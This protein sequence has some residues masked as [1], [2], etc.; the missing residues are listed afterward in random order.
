MQR[1]EVTPDPHII[2]GQPQEGSQTPASL[3]RPIPQPAQAE[4]SA[5]HL[6]RSKQTSVPTIQW[7]CSGLSRDRWIRLWKDMARPSKLTTLTQNNSL[8]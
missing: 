6:L 5:P 3:L 1:K 7:A 2:Q 4:P 8:K